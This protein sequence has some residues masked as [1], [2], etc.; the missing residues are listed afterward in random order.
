MALCCC[1]TLNTVEP[2]F[3]VVAA[4]SPV[5]ST[6]AAIFSSLIDGCLKYKHKE[7]PKTDPR[8]G[9]RLNYYV[10]I[11]PIEAR[12]EM[13]GSSVPLGRNHVSPSGAPSHRRALRIVL[14]FPPLTAPLTSATTQRLPHLN[15]RS[16]AATASKVDYSLGNTPRKGTPRDAAGQMGAPS[17]ILLLCPLLKYY[18]SLKNHLP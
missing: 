3:T 8:P 17:R 9:P 1:G 7:K 10:K 4:R 13:Q 11:G 12:S 6:S 2:L 14:T 16:E 18:G 15:L 5:V